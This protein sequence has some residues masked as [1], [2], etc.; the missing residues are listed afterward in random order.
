MSISTYEKWTQDLG[1]FYHI[2]ISWE[3][4]SY[5]TSHKNN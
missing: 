1:V 3:F 5:E 4:P 2:E